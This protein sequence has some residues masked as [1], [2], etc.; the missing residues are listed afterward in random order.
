MLLALRSM[1]PLPLVEVD[2]FDEGPP[3]DETSSAGEEPTRLTIRVEATPSRWRSLRWWAGVL[4]AIAAAA[5]GGKL[6]DSRRSGARQHLSPAEPK[7]VIL[8]RAPRAKRQ[9]GHRTAPH[10]AAHA[11]RRKHSRHRA[12]RGIRH[13]S[14]ARSRRVPSTPVPAPVEV[15]AA[16]RTEQPVS[17]RR[18]AS[19]APFGYLGR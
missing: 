11:V 9:V 14:L 1:S 7:V 5:A 3:R 12:H 17:G 2:P 16:P 6:I 13:R 10:V 18:G 4:M 19:A 15:P 8:G